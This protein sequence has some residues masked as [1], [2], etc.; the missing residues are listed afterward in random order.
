[1]K[2]VWSRHALR[3]LTRIRDYIEKDNPQAARKVAMR[4]VD[5]VE[6]LARQPHIGRPGRIVGTRELVIPDTPDIV[7]YRVRGERLEL[8]AIYHGRQKWPIN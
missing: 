8:I 1:M 2:I 4:I 6:G 3:H 5:G 7:P